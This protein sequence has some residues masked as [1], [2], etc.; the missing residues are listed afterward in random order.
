M[1]KKRNLLSYEDISYIRGYIDY[2]HAKCSFGTAQTSGENVC[3]EDE[4]VSIQ[5][6]VMRSIKETFTSR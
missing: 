5:T 6:M 1:K 3:L 2:S 4:S